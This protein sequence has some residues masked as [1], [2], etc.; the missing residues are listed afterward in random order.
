VTAAPVGKFLPA[1]IGSLHQERAEGVLVLEQNDGCRRLFWWNGDLI[2]LQSDVAGEQFGNYLLRQGVLDLPALQ[3]L[4]APGEGPRFGEKVVQWG[5]LTTKERDEHLKTLMTQILM[6]ALEHGVVELRWE[7]CPIGDRISG[8]LYFTLHHRQLVWSCF[9]ELRN[10]KDLSDLLYAQTGW[11]WKAPAELLISLKDLPLNPR[12]AY[13]LSFL[14][15]EPLGFET[16][17]GLTE[18]EEDETARLLLSL[19]A[20]GGLEL[21]EGELPFTTRNIPRV[22]PSPR[23]EPVQP[24]PGSRLVPPPLLRPNPPEAKPQTPHPPAANPAPPPLASAPSHT[25]IPLIPPPFKEPV[26]TIE[27]DQEDAEAN[28]DFAVGGILPPRLEAGAQEAED[29]EASSPVRNARRLFNKAKIMIMQERASEAIRALEQSLKLDP[30]SPKAY[31]AWLLLGK[32]RL[33]NPAW[34]TRAIEALQA[35]SRL[36]PKAAEPWALMGELYL[37]KSFK[38]NAIGCFKKALELDPSVPIPPELN[39]AEEVG[40]IKE[41]ATLIGRLGTGLKAMLKKQNP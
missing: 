26:I 27:L 5:L 2:Y 34:S 12:I 8:D 29:E 39:L 37:R 11:R 36:Q 24:P 14:G 15:P 38:A 18:L 33:G 22:P 1:V 40:E 7:P 4:L 17:M 25:S 16:F 28:I 23:P 41:P 31:E 10:L 35:A 9:Q 32:L 13:A 30:D 3:E 19:W 21:I 20:L 6:H